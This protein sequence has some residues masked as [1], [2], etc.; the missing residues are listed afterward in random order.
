MKFKGES[1][2]WF[3][4]SVVGVL[5]IAIT[6]IS[7]LGYALFVLNTIPLAFRWFYHSK[8]KKS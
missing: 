4:I 5:V 1:N 7:A 6:K 3:A 2:W 8:V